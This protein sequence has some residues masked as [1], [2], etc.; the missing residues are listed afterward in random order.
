MSRVFL[1]VVALVGGS[2]VDQN[3]LLQAQKHSTSSSSSP[4]WAFCSKQWS[5]CRCEGDIRWGNDQTWH[6][7]PLKGQES[8]EISCSIPQLPD[9]LPGDD[10][11]HCECLMK[12]GTKSFLQINPMMLEQNDAEDLGATEV[13]SCDMFYKARTNDNID[14]VQWQAMEGLC[15]QEWES[16]M[17]RKFR[18]GNRHINLDLRRE[19]FR[20]RVDPRFKE[21]MQRMTKNGWFEKAWVTYVAGS[22]DS[23]YIQE[24]LQLIKSVHVF[25]T[26]PIVLFNFGNEIPAAWTPELFPQLVVLH[27]KPMP[28][29][30]PIARSFNFNKLRAILM[31]RVKTAAL[32]D[33]DQFVGPNADILFNRTESYVDKEYPFPLMPTHFLDWSSKHQLHAPWW[34]RYCPDPDKPCPMQTMRWAHAHP[35]WTFWALPFFGRWVR[36]HFRDELLPGTMFEGF[37]APPLRVGDIM[38][39]EDLLNVALWEDRATKQ[40]CKM[41][42]PDT[43]EFESLLSWQPSDADRCLDWKSGCDNIGGD[44]RWYKNGVPKVYWTAHHAVHPN[45]TSDI[46]LRIQEKYKEGKWP[47]AIVYDKKFWNSSSELHQAH[48]DLPCLI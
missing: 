40:W 13:V 19:L 27:S 33:A 12:P 30:R 16:R 46:L 2:K 39:D 45:V 42:V 48:P 36:R 25:S 14:M 11:K 4:V 18:A 31:S 32:V 15:S 22:A 5:N 43:V 20:A 41:D 29:A 7:I 34:P 38:E 35:T 3:C 44:E 8:Q 24:A 10:F 37:H 6:T 26:Q 17:F 28:T 9:V 47:P 21:S 1:A 23:L